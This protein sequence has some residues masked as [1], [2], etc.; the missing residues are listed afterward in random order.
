M[1]GRRLPTV[2][3]RTLLLHIRSNPS[4]RA[5]S[6]DTGLDRRTVHSYR[7]WAQQQNLLTEPLLSLEELQ[8]RREATLSD[9]LPPQNASSVEPYREIVVRLRR[10][11]VQRRA[12]FAR[13]KERG[14][15][16]SYASVY[17][18]VKA[19]EP[20]TPDVCVR[21]ETQPGEDAQVDFGEVGRLPD[22]SGKMGKVYAFVMTLSWSRHQYVE[23]VCDQKVE[24]WLGLHVR[25]FA[26]FG[27]VPRRVTCDNLKAAIVQAAFDDP[28]ANRA[29]AECAE[30]YGFRIAPC[31]PRTPQHKGKVERGVAFVQGNFW[32]GR[33]L[34]KIATANQA[35][36]VWC[37]QEAGERV[38]GTTKE[39]PLTRYN[40]T[41]RARL[42][43]LPSTAY[44]MAVMKAAKLHRD[45]Y[46]VFD[47]A[48]Y[49]AP[50]RLVGQKLWVRGGLAQVRLYDS[51]YQ[52]VA[53][54]ERAGQPGER[55]THPDHLP[56]HKLPGLLQTRQSCLEDAARIGTATAQVVQTLLDDPILERLPSAGRLVRLQ[57]KYSPA[58]LEAACARALRFDDPTYTTV[59]RILREGLENAALP[60]EAPAPAPSPAFTFARP[61][62]E[63]FGALV[64][65][66]TWN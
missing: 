9:T 36:R 26:F 33:E 37:L 32:A 51:A 10:E 44:D 56:P 64:G 62:E 14:Y 20:A 41:E 55:L 29:Y 54:H 49:S 60:E 43:P 11:N 1:P 22:A 27:G 50:F 8:Q 45:G 4:D 18:F 48:Y 21:V 34:T 24:T 19:L 42:L 28:V 52:C 35:A 53:T 30:H 66:L 40:D 58:R 63:I 2:D 65:G 59:K 23:F 12:I 61:V 47:N 46:I 17:R 31:R 3:I 38:H 6:R 5:V 13:L 57:A 16:G 25:A 39:R 7:Q 15:K